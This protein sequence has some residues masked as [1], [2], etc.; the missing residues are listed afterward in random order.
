MRAS[1][2]RRAA[3]GEVCRV[4]MTTGYEIYGFRGN[5][6]TFLGA[7]P[8]ERAEAEREAH[9]FLNLPDVQGVR[10]VAE[11]DAQDGTFVPRVVYRRDKSSGLPPFKLT[12]RAA[13]GRGG[14]GRRPSPRPA[15]GGV[16]PAGYGA[17]A[18]AVDLAPAAEARAPRAAAVA[19]AAERKG[20]GF[21]LGGFLSDLFSS[22]FVNQQSAD[23]GRSGAD[24]RAEPQRIDGL[25][26]PSI[27]DDDF[28]VGT[29]RKEV[30]RQDS[31]TLLRYLYANLQFVRVKTDMAPNG[32]LSQTDVFACYLFFAGAAEEQARRQQRPQNE[33]RRVIATVLRNVAKSDDDARRFALHYEEYL[34]DPRQAK[35]FAQGREGYIAWAKGSGSPESLS[36]ALQEWR[37]LPDAKPAAPGAVDAASD[38]DLITVM[39]TDIVGSTEHSATYGDELHMQLIAAHDRIVRGAIGSFKG[40][41]IKHLGDGIM[42]SFSTVQ[43]GVRAALRIQSE[44]AE[45]PVTDP[46]LALTIRIG[47]NAGTPIRM[48][49]DLFGSTVQLSA[50]LCSACPAGEVAASE[51]VVKRFPDGATLFRPIGSKTLKGFPEPV[52]IFAV[53]P[54]RG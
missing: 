33:F 43:D 26:E 17:R 6:W 20:G 36:K 9:K 49:A 21:S 19:A 35:V 3:K 45:T 8:G 32:K 13:M 53:A 47:L 48:G 44:V 2:S 52:P 29:G 37:T 46:R 7:N 50:R 12:E 16:E 5:A 18:D 15:A 39:F 54:G 40:V 27:E 28:K 31:E 30:V 42:A 22:L 1:S 10:L 23:R 34:A 41:E 24:G 38:K 4:R 14:G 11:V 51:T 25:V